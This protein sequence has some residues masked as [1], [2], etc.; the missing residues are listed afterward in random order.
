TRRV[1][2]GLDELVDAFARHFVLPMRRARL[3]IPLDRFDLVDLLHREGDVRRE[4]HRADGVWIEAEY[5]LRYAKNFMP[6]V[7]RKESEVAE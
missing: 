4:E 7:V 2:A 1:G 6:Y 5:P 3:Q